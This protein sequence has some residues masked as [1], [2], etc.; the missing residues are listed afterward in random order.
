MTRALSTAALLVL[1]LVTGLAL[2]LFRPFLAYPEPAALSCLD[3]PAETKLSL[4]I[5]SA[6]SD[7]AYLQPDDLVTVSAGILGGK[8]SRIVR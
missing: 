5:D 2:Y 6:A 8:T 3:P 7:P 1:L 4:M